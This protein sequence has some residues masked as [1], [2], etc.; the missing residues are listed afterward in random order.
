[1]NSKSYNIVIELTALQ[2]SGVFRNL[3][4]PSIFEEA[5]LARS[6]SNEKKVYN[7]DAML[8]Q[9]GYYFLLSLAR[10]AFTN[11]DGSFDNKRVLMTNAINEIHDRGMECVQLGLHDIAELIIECCMI[12]KYD[13]FKNMDEFRK[14]CG[15]KFSNIFGVTYEKAK[16]EWTELS[17]K[18]SSMNKIEAFNYAIDRNLEFIKFANSILPEEDKATPVKLLASQSV[19]DEER[20]NMEDGF[21]KCVKKLKKSFKEE[22]K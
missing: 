8:V 2:A 4:K 17:K 6:S 22:K 19:T 12:D 21:S 1:M 16:E 3:K 11:D 7:H 18:Y 9:S 5:G 20:N 15:D 13:K 10:A 14:I